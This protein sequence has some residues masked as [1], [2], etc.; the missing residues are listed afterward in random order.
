MKKLF[1]VLLLACTPA[2]AQRPS[3]PAL[4]VPQQAPP[5]DMAPVPD[6]LPLPAGVTMGA[7]ASVAFDARGHLLVLTRGEQAFFEFDENGKFIR[8]FGDRLF[9]RA[10]G[11]RFDREGNIW[12]TDVG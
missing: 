9:T 8:A 7:P 6:A 10:H 1:V 12:A 2:Y 11:L 3:D 5:L 4:M